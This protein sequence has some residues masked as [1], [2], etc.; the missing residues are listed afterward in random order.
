MIAHLTFSPNRSIRNKINEIQ[1]GLVFSAKYSAA[2]PPKRY[3]ISQEA[4]KKLF[5]EFRFGVKTDPD[6]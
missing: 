2:P 5:G 6:N 3:T 1:R 4:M